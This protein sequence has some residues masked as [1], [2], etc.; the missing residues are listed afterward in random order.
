M[1]YPWGI[2]PNLWQTS[3]FLT[4]QS[5][6]NIHDMFQNN[7]QYAHEYTPQGQWWGI[8]NIK[9]N[10]NQISQWKIVIE[11]LQCTFPNGQ[12]FSYDCQWKKFNGAHFLNEDGD[13]IYGIEC[14]LENFNS[15]FANKK[16]VELSLV[17]QNNSF[18]QDN[19][20]PMVT[21][22]RDTSDINDINAVNIKMPVVSLMPTD[23]IKNNNNYIPLFR[24]NVQ[25]NIF[26][27][28]DFQYPIIFIKSSTLIGKN[29]EIFITN[30]YEKIIYIQQE[31]KNDMTI[32][33]FLQ[34]LMAYV[35]SMNSLLKNNMLTTE[36]WFHSSLILLGNLETFLNFN[37]KVY[38]FNSKD[39]LSTYNEI[40][41]RIEEICNK[42]YQVGVVG[43]FQYQDMN[44]S[45]FIDFVW[46]DNNFYLDFS[47]PIDKNN[48][49]NWVEN[50][51]ITESNQLDNCILNKTR[52]FDRH[53]LD[54][55]VNGSN[56][57]C[58]LRYNINNLYKYPH[59]LVIFNPQEIQQMTINLV[60]K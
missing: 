37:C 35:F 56:D 20:I 22:M 12:N 31:I 27:M 10:I 59:N 4:T 2:Y 45:L 57:F 44:W 21:E 13:K 60:K 1:Y 3:D 39:L 8:H 58:W 30:L 51:I 11:N 26:N 15:I 46:E 25:N 7:W 16:E 17:I 18:Q 49:I 29:L 42:I 47:A 41:Q 19:F 54:S 34:P 5:L 24:I 55:K 28:I 53:L 48:L 43:K 23:L 9:Y 36:K 6:T 52:G 33:N 14:D 40:I 32:K 50:S 38:Y